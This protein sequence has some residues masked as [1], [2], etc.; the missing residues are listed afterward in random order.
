MGE[1]L[2][3]NET[4]KIDVKELEERILHMWRYL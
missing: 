2:M 1:L 3:T 4:Q